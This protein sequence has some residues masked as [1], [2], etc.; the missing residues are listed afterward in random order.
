MGRFVNPRSKY[1]DLSNI[2]LVGGKLDF[3]ETGTSDRKDTFKDDDESD[4][5]KNTNPLILNGDG[6]VPNCFATG[7]AR[8]R[9][10]NA[11]DEV[12]WDLDPVSFGDDTGGFSA[13]SSTRTYDKN[14]TVVFNDVFYLSKIN[15][16]QNNQPDTSEEEWEEIEFTRLYNS[17]TTYLINDNVTEDGFEYRSLQGSNLNNL[18]SS[19]PTF[20][21]LA[22]TNALNNRII[23][24]SNAT[25]SGDAMNLAMATAASL[26]F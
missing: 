15:E 10:L 9:L 7:S 21:E 24:V 14:D 8:V 1:T 3:F 19:S 26:Y 22:G 18:P 5:L 12:Q 25:T 4:A 20:W 17:T 11:D 2:I 16:N 13:Y 6:T 23:N